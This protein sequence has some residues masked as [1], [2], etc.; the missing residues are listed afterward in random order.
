MVQ[1]AVRSQ[2]NMACRKPSIFT[3]FISWSLQLFS[4]RYAPIFD[5]QSLIAHLLSD[6]RKF[7]WRKY[8]AMLENISD[9]IEPQSLENMEAK[10]GFYALKLHE[11]RGGSASN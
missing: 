10:V 4:D 2:L 8:I 3:F 9:Y 5:L 6:T 11:L 1:D 7:S